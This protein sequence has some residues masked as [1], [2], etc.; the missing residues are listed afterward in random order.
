MC[1]IPAVKEDFPETRKQKTEKSYREMMKSDTK[2]ELTAQSK[3]RKRRERNIR[4]NVE[5]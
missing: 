4:I 5:K 2:S 1:Q 3:L